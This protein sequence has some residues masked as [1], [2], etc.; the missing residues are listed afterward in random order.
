[1]KHCGMIGFHLFLVVLWGCASNPDIE[2]EEAEV[3]SAKPTEEVEKKPVEKVVKQAPK[4]Q[5]EIIIAPEVTTSYIS[6]S[7]TIE[8]KEQPQLQLA[9][10]EGEIYKEVISRWLNKAGFERVGYLLGE[11]EERVL[12]R[13]VQTTE[14]H[15]SDIASAIEHIVKLAVI[16]DRA[17][18]Q[19]ESADKGF[20]SGLEVNDFITTAADKEKK[21]EEQK[22]I[23]IEARLNPR[24]REAIIT[25]SLLPTV[26][27]NVQEGSLKDNYI[28]LADFYDWR[29]TGEFYL[30]RDYKISFGYPIVTEVGNIKSALTMLL[31]PFNDLRGALVPSVRQVY[32]LSEQD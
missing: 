9:V 4:K 32:I 28:R 24:H 16:Q 26:M 31:T 25:S 15:Y 29:A 8:L 30:G 20:Y 10:F 12:A 5:P 14:V 18:Y 6:E 2:P 23:K 1:M 3:S 7:A 13:V 19:K 27:F 21:A 22:P 17:E 11:R